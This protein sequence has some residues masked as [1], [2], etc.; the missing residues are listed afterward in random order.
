M[1]VSDCTGKI[2]LQVGPGKFLFRRRKNR[3][4]RCAFPAATEPQ[5]AVCDPDSSEQTALFIDPSHFNRKS[6]GL[7]VPRS[8]EI[9]DQEKCDQTDN[10]P[11]VRNVVREEN[12][13]AHEGVKP[14]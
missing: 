3:V 8:Q 12:P 1:Y 13:V 10:G 14:V 2:R 11:L 5:E 4:E 7:F 9:V 6:V